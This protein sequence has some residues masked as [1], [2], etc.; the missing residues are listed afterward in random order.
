MKKFA[1]MVIVGLLT[2]GSAWGDLIPLPSEYARLEWIQATGYQYLDAEYV[3]AADDIFE[4]DCSV[5]F[6]QTRTYANLFGTRKGSN[7]DH[8]IALFLAAN[9]KTTPTVRYYRDGTNGLLEGFPVDQRVT[10]TF[11]ETGVAWATAG[12]EQT[13]RVE[14]TPT[15]HEGGNSSLMIFGLNNVTSATGFSPDGNSPSCA[16]IY[17][18]KI[19]GGDGT[20]RRSF[21]PCR[22]YA[23][24]EAGLW[25]EVE[26]K[27]HGNRGTRR[28]FGSDVEEAETLVDYMSATGTQAINTGYLHAF[29]DTFIAD[30]TAVFPQ[31]KIY[32]NIF[33]A[34]KSG[35]N[36]VNATSF[37]MSSNSKTEPKAGYTR[38]GG[39]N[40]T[41]GS[42]NFPANKRM[43]LTCGPTQATWQTMDGK[44]NGSISVTPTK[45]EGGYNPIVI[46][47]LNNTG[48]ANGC[49]LDGNSWATANLYSFRIVK[50]DSTVVHDYEP[51]RMAD[52]EVKLFDLITGQSFNNNAKSSSGDFGFG[53]AYTTNGTTLCVHEGV[54]T[55]D[56]L[57]NWTAVEKVGVHRVDA[58]GVT[59]RFP[60][61]TLNRG[62]FSLQDGT[63]KTYGIDQALTLK[64]GAHLTFDIGPTGCDVLAPSS[65]V[66]EEATA[67][68]PVVLTVTI[69][70]EADL[71]REYA[72]IAS[73][74][75]GSGRPTNIRIEGA[76]MV[77]EIRG[78]ALMLRYDDPSVPVHATWIGTD[79]SAVDDPACWIC[80][81]SEGTRLPGVLPTGLTLVDLPDGCVFNCPVGASF[82]CRSIVFPATLG[83][84]CDWRGLL[85]PINST[86]NLNGHK[87]YLSQLA[88][89][90]TLMDTV[91]EEF[92]FVDY[93]S[94]DGRQVVDTH[95]LFQAY[96]TF[97]VDF[98]PIFPQA[99]TY[100]VVFGTRNNG[101]NANNAT[102]FFLCTG[103]KDAVNASY[104][105]ANAYQKTTDF[106]TN[107]RL[108]LTCNET[109]ASWL[110]ADGLT[111]GSLA[112]SGTKHDNGLF[113]LI[114]FGMNNGK[115]G[116]L[117][118]DGNSW[119]KM[120]LHSFQIRSKNL[121]VMRNFVPAKRLSDGVYGLYETC[122]REFL[123]AES[124]V[125]TA[126]LSGEP[127]AAVSARPAG[128]VHL[129]VPEDT[130]VRSE[131]LLLKGSLKFVK[132]G[133]GTLLL[134]KNDQ[135]YLGGTEI[136]EGTVRRALAG[137]GTFFGFGGDVTIDP[138]GTVDF[139]GY[140]NQSLE[141]FV[142]AGG[143]IKSTTNRSQQGYDWLQQVALTADS[144]IIC[145]GAG[146]VG[147][148]WA[149]GT[150]EMNGH[151]LDLVTA[152][153]KG[154]YMGN[155]TVTGGGKIVVRGGGLFYLGNS[156]A[157]ASTHNVH[158]ETT[159]LEIRDVALTVCCSDILLG[160]Y[161][162]QQPADKA[163]AGEGVM[164][165]AQTFTP[166]T[167]T[168]YPCQL[169]DG[170]C[171]DF[172]ARTTELQGQSL[173][174]AEE[175]TTIQIHL[176]SRHVRNN[177]RLM[178]WDEIPAVKFGATRASRCSVVVETD[179]L[180]IFRGFTVFV[181]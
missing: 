18:F 48:T 75:A 29:D 100:P 167:D 59:S 81:N 97:I 85:Q 47:G 163:L 20:V 74:L 121:K 130:E 120:D 27:F 66:L 153:S 49:E 119:A 110:T 157:S 175:A 35:N 16:T 89:T 57:K 67:D 58:S 177:E 161:T 10:M 139:D 14:I 45:E 54:L 144:T 84:D 101:S 159:T 51:H 99:K 151:Q 62:N 95:Y 19:T 88:G 44:V 143:T 170:A 181:R 107:Q 68:N 17:S 3:F 126:A 164:R 141:R 73:G 40:F 176:G 129:D 148:G 43:T 132:E 50:S 135:A 137:T 37:F 116:T 106:P 64:G 134:A 158:A 142:L 39:T 127:V 83:G 28:L 124:T 113:S 33:G 152:G 8:A 173:K 140:G 138:E 13:G 65:V 52:G 22:R 60:S 133:A 168:F 105:R 61:L 69:D 6:P 4:V 9:S 86:I 92:V 108:T 1:G 102:S 169:L 25:D 2:L 42:G 34:R 77:A 145:D 38:S 155:L 125:S 154:I 12:G 117:S 172:S 114:I 23:D 94:A 82:T 103:N 111:C 174:Y 31:A 78:G 109:S 15:K 178:T 72:V 98:N 180:Y 118:I 30:F 76:S 11:T 165:V 55:D 79:E 156:S 166:V 7:T 115:T 41:G 179:G 123:T 5:N 36:S 136:R 160:G 26:G 90:G 80:E 63:A 91:N 70:P 162:S 149:Q 24:G 46:F 56:L 147:A 96:D 21:I 87:L 150:L 71:T 112:V 128:E 171:I 104:H 32:P 122:T 53:C 131:T 93:V 146:F